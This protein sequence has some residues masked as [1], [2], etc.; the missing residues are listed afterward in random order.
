MKYT[1]H[2]IAACVLLVVVVVAV[3]VQVMAL[4]ELEAGRLARTE[5]NLARAQ[6]HFLYAARWYLPLVPTS[7][8][9]VGELLEVG[10]SY[11]ALQDYAAAVSAYDDARGALYATAWLVVPGGELLSRAN[12]GYAGA[13]A[14]WKALRQPG[15]DIAEETARFLALA[16]G[17]EVA[18]P[19][20]SLVMGLSFLAY[21]GALGLL[22]WRWDRKETRRWP[23]GVAAGI[24]F[25]VWVVAMVMI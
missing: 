16:E 3:R 12:R 23:Y 24:S 6:T 7:R 1:V 2:I 19:W 9:A 21:L 13:L 14:N 10:D 17:V 20:W 11:L 22:A 5:G 25:A 8:Q 18:N 4:G 15:T